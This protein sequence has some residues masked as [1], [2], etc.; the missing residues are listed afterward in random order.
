MNYVHCVFKEEVTVGLTVV[1]KDTHVRLDLVVGIL[2]TV[3][4]F[5]YHFIV[6]W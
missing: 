6:T 5:L 3:T 2:S 4:K 1:M